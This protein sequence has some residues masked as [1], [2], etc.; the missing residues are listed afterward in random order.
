MKCCSL[1]L[2]GGV[3]KTLIATLVLAPKM[4][5][6]KIIAVESINE[7]GKEAYGVE[8]EK[9]LGEKFQRLY[10]EI[11]LLDDVIVDVGASNVVPFLE[12]L[13][14]YGNAHRE[15]DAFVVPSTSGTKEQKETISMVN[16]LAGLGIEPARIKVVCN[17]VA[18]D[19]K[20]EFA[21]LFDFAAKS[22]TCELNPESAIWENELMDLLHVHKM[23]LDDVLNDKTDHRAFARGLGPDADPKLLALHLDLHI[24]QDLAL[25]VRDNFD[26]AYGA[27]FPEE[28]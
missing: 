5:G 2:L 23:S 27:L 9:I 21:A 6:T 24:M 13:V 28:V 8:V 4:P 15:F 14:K 3:G 12:G 20:E 11:M 22:G 10:K 25:V 1:N 7:T 17:R 26:R 16:T 19:V 18:E